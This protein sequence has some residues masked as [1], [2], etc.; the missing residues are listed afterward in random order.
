MNDVWHLGEI[1]WLLSALSDAELQQ[2][3]VASRIRDYSRH[4][5]V[6]SPSE[7]PNSV[8]LLASGRVRIYRISPHGGETTFGYVEVGELFGE[9][10]ALGDYPRESF[11]EA[12]TASRVWRIRAAVLKE[13]LKGH[14][15][16]V[17]EVAQ[18]VGGR[19]KRIENRVEDLVFRNVR[20]RLV[21][22]LLLLAED[23][24][25]VRP[26]GVALDLKISQ[27]ELATLVGASRQ[28]VNGTLRELEEEQLIRVRDRR[29]VLPEI[30]R[31]RE[32]E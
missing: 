7:K 8:Y 4:E 1:D 24:G 19:L 5:V 11:A 27:G 22:I 21:R 28:T 10:A 15:G 23:F 12:A 17:V 31:L 26:D 14:P 18:Q 3:Q 2:L 6:F 25:L 9:M 32:I 13:L 20:S 16:L 29:I 30:E